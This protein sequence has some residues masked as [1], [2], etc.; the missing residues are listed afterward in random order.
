MK[1]KKTKTLTVKVTQRDID[2]ALKAPQ[3][4]AACETC[5]VARA[6]KREDKT[7]RCGGTTAWRYRPI[8]CGMRAMDDVAFLPAEARQFVANFDA[9]KPVRPFTFKLKVPA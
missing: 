2:L 5:A 8:G 9:R 6:L 3:S 7:L 4:K 1:K